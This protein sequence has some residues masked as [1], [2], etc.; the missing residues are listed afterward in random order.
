M[1]EHSP[2]ALHLCR[3]LIGSSWLRALL[4]PG[5]A[6]LQR[7][8]F[9]RTIGRNRPTACSCHL[10]PWPSIQTPSFFVSSS[11]LMSIAEESGL[12]IDCREPQDI[13]SSTMRCARSLL[14]AADRRCPTHANRII[15]KHQMTD[16]YPWSTQGTEYTR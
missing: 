14:H 7:S 6:L 11:L 10:W 4:V 9:Q 15:A 2:P 8:D 16:R 1:L 13:G 3:P 12:C 5:R